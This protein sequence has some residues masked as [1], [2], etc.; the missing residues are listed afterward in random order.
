[1][2]DEAILLVDVAERIATITLNR[3]QARNALSRALSAQF[4]E[5]M[6]ALD[7]RDDVAVI[8]LTGADP[9][10][11]AGLD[12]RELA[13]TPGILGAA[14]AVRDDPATMSKGMLPAMSTPVIGAINGVTVTG[15]LEL[16]LSCDFLVASER[17]KF[18][19]TH[20]RV[21]LVPGGGLSVMLPQAVGL[22]R[23]REMSFTGTFVDARQA[24]EWGLVNHVVPHEELLPFCRA[25]AAEIAGNDRA[26]VSRM[27]ATYTEVSDADGGAGWAIEQRVF[28]AWRDSRSITDEVG[29]RAAS[30]MT[31]GRAQ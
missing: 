31:R 21:G 4:A 28:S 30:V 12:L 13:A 19:D 27:R 29:S 26:A 11:C 9:G 2:S 6:R 22:R 10:F 7:A 8:I 14:G 15:G 1:V 16:A 23:A 20:A 17:A 25:L 18:G 5:S 3:P 24:L